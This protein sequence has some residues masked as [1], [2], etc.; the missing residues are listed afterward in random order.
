[1]S[2]HMHKDKSIYQYAKIF[3]ITVMKYMKLMYNWGSS[4]GTKVALNATKYYS[5]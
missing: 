3:C 2:K 1:M 4:A 5:P